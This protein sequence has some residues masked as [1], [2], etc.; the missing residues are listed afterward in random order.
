MD[1]VDTEQTLDCLCT[2]PAAAMDTQALEKT[3]PSKKGRLPW[4]DSELA[5]LLR[6]R[7]TLFRRY[8]RTGQQVLY[9]EFITLRKEFDVMDWR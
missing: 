1:V 5:Q 4:I 8:K 2:N 7:V 3:V 6:R 9:D